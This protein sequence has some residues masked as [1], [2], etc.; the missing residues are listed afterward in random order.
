R[1]PPRATLSAATANADGLRV[2]STPL[3]VAGALLIAVGF[4]RSGHT[5]TTDPTALMFGADVLHVVAAG[6]WAG[7]LVLLAGALRAARSGRVAP[8]A[9]ATRVARFSTMAAVVS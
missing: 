1:R 5:E 4:A 8:A 7:G 3:A 2:V 6:A 9:V